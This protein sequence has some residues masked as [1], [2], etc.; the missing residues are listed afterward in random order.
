MITA[1]TRHK[2]LRFFRQLRVLAGLV[3]FCIFVDHTY[4]AAREHTFVYF[5]QFINH[6]AAQHKVLVLAAQVKGAVFC[7]AIVKHT[8]W[9]IVDS[10]IG[11]KLRCQQV[12]VNGNTAGKWVDFLQAQIAE[13]QGIRVDI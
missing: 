8:I 3:K 5:L 7:L 10:A 1:E 12:I 6:E 2:N 4:Q 13:H 11:Q 9:Q